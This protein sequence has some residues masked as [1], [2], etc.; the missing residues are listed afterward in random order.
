MVPSAAA[1][2]P[3]G[4]VQKDIVDTWRNMGLGKFVGVVGTP[5]TKV[6]YRAGQTDPDTKITDKIVRV[7]TTVVCSPFLTLPI[8]NWP[9]ISA[10]MPFTISS[11]AEMENPDNAG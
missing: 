7:D 8:G 6:T 5:Q 4:E 1:L 3:G 11:E 2:A 9:G 10:P